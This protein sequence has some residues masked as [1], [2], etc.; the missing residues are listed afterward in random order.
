[1]R[2]KKVKKDSKSTL[3]GTPF[4]WVV[5]NFVELK[6]DPNAKALY[7]KF[8]NRKTG[9]VALTIPANKGR[10]G[11]VN[12]DYDTVGVVGIEVLG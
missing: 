9:K 10:D 5:P 11:S 8:L 2:S 3:L 6:Y 4:T 7:L 1:M 12:I